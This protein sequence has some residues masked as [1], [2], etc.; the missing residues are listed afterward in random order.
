MDIG[1]KDPSL[2]LSYKPDIFR[3]IPKWFPARW[4]AAQQQPK[5]QPNQPFRPSALLQILLLFDVV[6]LDLTTVFDIL[7]AK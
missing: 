3:W 6:K 1:V 5:T 2:S 4:T 7:F